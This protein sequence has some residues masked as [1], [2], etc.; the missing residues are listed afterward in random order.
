MKA[1]FN[2][3][4][5]LL[6][7]FII[8][9][10]VYAQKV[11]RETI[12]YAGS[13]YKKSGYYYDTLRGGTPKIDKA[14]YFTDDRKSHFRNYNSQQFNFNKLNSFAYDEN[15]SFKNGDQI[16]FFSK[17]TGKIR[18][19]TT[20]STIIKECA[21]KIAKPFIWTRNDISILKDNSK[22][23]FYI[24]AETVFNY[25]VYQLNH[26]TGKT[27]LLTKTNDVWNNPNFRIENGQLHYQKS[28]AGKLENYTLNLKN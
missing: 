2:S 8:A 19:T 1:F 5:L 25:Y 18:I 20:D 14:S 16:I 12:Y 4:F 26:Q 23:E 3:P 13:L 24:I 22:L 27:K 17:N 9:F 28:K 11:E 6:F 15:A 21:I 7:F 10:N